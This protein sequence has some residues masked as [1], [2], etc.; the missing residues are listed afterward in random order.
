MIWYLEL[1]EGAQHKF[2]EI[3]FENTELTIRYG[4]IG[5]TGQIQKKSFSSYEA[6]L[7]EAEKRIK[8]K[9]KNGYVD[10][11]L[12]E[13]EKKSIE[14]KRIPK[15]QMIGFTAVSTPI[16]EPITKFGGQPVWIDEPRWAVDGTNGKKIPF[17]CQIRLE[18]EIFGNIEAKMAY[19]FHGASDEEYDW[20]T[21][22]GN[23]AIVLQPGNIVFRAWDWDTKFPDAFLH[24]AIGPSA[25]RYDS[26]QE[27]PLV[28]IECRVECIA[29]DDPAYIFHEKRENWDEAKQNDYW[30]LL[31]GHK[32][33]GTPN[34]W[35]DDDFPESSDEAMSNW[36][37]LMQMEASGTVS[38]RIDQPFDV[39]YGDG[40]CGWWFISKDGK[41]L[42]YTERCH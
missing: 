25:W 24:E 10:A 17:L 30:E 11:I 23:T 39:S 19:I 27:N 26:T 15:L 40:G 29:G 13:R 33:G 3:Q 28:G 8:E 22:H 20:S 14:K 4:R 35:D 36:N 21:D 32:I 5:D 18:P 12:G 38:A 41:N 31:S 16:L 37:L 7:A 42:Y 1:S 9:R 6:A 2:Y 34:L